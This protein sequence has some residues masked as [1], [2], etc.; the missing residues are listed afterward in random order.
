MV[1]CCRVGDEG[2]GAAEMDAAARRRKHDDRR[3]MMAGLLVYAVVRMRQ[4]GWDRMLNT[5]LR[6]NIVWT[7][8][9]RFNSREGL[10]RTASNMTNASEGIRMGRNKRHI[11]PGSE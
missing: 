6:Y 7:S 4:R 9:K 10:P 8:Q 1:N 2:T 3:R 11:R 5:W